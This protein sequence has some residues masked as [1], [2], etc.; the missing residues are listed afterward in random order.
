MPDP[1]DASWFEDT[2]QLDAMLTD[3][4]ATDTRTVSSITDAEFVIEAFRDAR[5]ETPWTGLDRGDVANRL[6]TLVNDPR[7]I[8]Q[9]GLNLCG[10][11][12]LI[13]IWAARDPLAFASFATELYDAG[14]ADIGSMSIAPT[15]ALLAQDFNE[16]TDA[17]ATWG[18]D[19]M[20]LSAIRNTDSPFWQPEWVGDPAQELAGLTRPEELADWLRATGLYRSVR[21]EGNWV[22]PAGIPHATDISMFDGR[23]VALLLHINLIRA[24]RHTALDDTF[25]IDQFPNHWVVGLNE[26]SV[27]AQTGDVRLSL[28]TWGRGAG[29][30]LDLLVPR[31][32]FVDNYYGAVI[33]DLA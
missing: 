15:D 33:A 1:Q 20:V 4:R 9:G 7:S 25:L 17:A 18:A 23:D 30:T 28:W 22:S 29:S 3:K 2:E 8:Q 10:P 5:T 16:T 13:C 27:D 24:A 21:D 19:W 11:A 31:Q 32:E 26:I 12:A 6:V 14:A